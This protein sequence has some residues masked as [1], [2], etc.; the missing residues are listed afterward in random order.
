MGMI[1]FSLSNELLPK[2]LI[3]LS[4]DYLDE[5]FPGLIK[6]YG[7]GQPVTIQIETVEAPTV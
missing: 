1:S 7:T 4:T 2:E 6:R 5:F 3:D